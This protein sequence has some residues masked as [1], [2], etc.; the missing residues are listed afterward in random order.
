MKKTIFFGAVLLMIAV[1][2]CQRETTVPTLP[3][4]GQSTNLQQVSDR[5][6]CDNISISGGNGLGICGLALGTGS[7]DLCTG[8]PSN[9]AVIS[10]NSVSYT[11]D[12]QG[13]FMLYNFGVNPVTVTVSFNCDFQ[14]VNLTIP[15]NS[16]ALYKID[17]DPFGCCYP[18]PVP[19]C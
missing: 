7:C 17:T 12:G 10:G 1:S 3:D 9:D 2:S 13:F 14:A 5:G 6:P 16:K 11:L 19:V 18:V 4:S 15:G 8:I